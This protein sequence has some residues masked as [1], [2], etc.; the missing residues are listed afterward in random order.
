M[1]DFEDDFITRL[2]QQEEAAFSQFYEMTIDVFYRYL[3]GRYYL[4]E[5]DTQDLLSDFYVKCRKGLSKYNPEYKFETYVWTILKNHAKDFFK[6]KKSVQ[7]KDEHMDSASLVSQ[8]EDEMLED[9]Q[10]EYDFDIIHET[11]QSIDEQS[12]EVIYMR[13]IDEMSYEEMSE[14]LGLSQDAV[15]QRLSRA[16]KKI[17]N[18]VEELDTQ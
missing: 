1:F 11:M 3:R 4:S 10:K 7:L 5:G 18:H 12:Y 17:K 2:V 14:F 8:W 13:Y 16:L 6:K 15:R 9:L